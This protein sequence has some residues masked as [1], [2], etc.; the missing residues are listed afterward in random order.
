MKYRGKWVAL[1]T[2]PADFTPICEADVIQF[3]AHKRQFDKRKTQLLGASVDTLESHRKWKKS[4]EEQSTVRISYPLV[5]DPNRE[6]AN[7]YGLLHKEKNVT[8]RGV[9]IIDPEGTL[10][11]VA[12]YPLEVGRNVDE[13]IR[14]LRILQRAVELSGLTESKRAEELSKIIQ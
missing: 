11:Y 1:F 5:A 8:Y 2:Y 14:V 12:I 6:L 7:K 9:F 10:R 13:T 4:I 3:A